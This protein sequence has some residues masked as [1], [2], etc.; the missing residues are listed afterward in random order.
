MPVG[1][2]LLPH[3]DIL[4][5]ATKGFTYVTHIFHTSAA[6]IYGLRVVATG[7]PI[8]FYIEIWDHEQDAHWENHTLKYS[9]KITLAPEAKIQE[10]SDL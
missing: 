6:H 9:Q 1:S 2:P 7:K 5:P 8:S 3:S 10:V 4:P